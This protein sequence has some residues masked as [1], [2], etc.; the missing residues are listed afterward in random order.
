VNGVVYTA[1]NVEIVFFDAMCMDGMRGKWRDGS[2]YH[3]ELR[4]LSHFYSSNMSKTVKYLKIKANETLRRRNLIDLLDEVGVAEDEVG[5]EE[6]LGN[7]DTESDL[8]D[9]VIA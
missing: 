8:G 1:I 4:V 5:A 6:E 7:G 2:R 3:G 9:G